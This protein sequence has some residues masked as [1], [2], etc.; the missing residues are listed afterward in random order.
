MCRVNVS[1]NFLM[2]NWHLPSENFSFTMK[3]NF[4]FSHTELA[5][6]TGVAAILRFPMPEL[7]DDETD[8]EDND[9]D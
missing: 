6:L 9:S 5:Q 7:E 3:T 2:P 4:R 1:L 8:N